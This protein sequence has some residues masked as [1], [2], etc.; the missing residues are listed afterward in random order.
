MRLLYLC[1]VFVNCEKFIKNLN[2]NSC[3]NCIHYKP[4]FFGP[5][6]SN[7]ANFGDK[8]II[9]NKI[10]YEYTDHC[11][12]NEKKCGKEGKYFEK[13][14]NII[15]NIYKNQIINNFPLNMSVIF[16]T[17]SVINSIY[18]CYLI[19]QTINFRN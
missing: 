19:C 9:T 10:T 13:D 15:S 8:D 6:L 12:D 16:I 17:L 4:S 3:R 18:F 14:N 2:V 11:R 5:E 7:C 1:V